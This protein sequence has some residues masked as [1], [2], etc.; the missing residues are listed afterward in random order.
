MST[1]QPPGL[2]PEKPSLSQPVQPSPMPPYG[3][4]SPPP[5]PPSETGWLSWLT[6]VK[7][8]TISNVLVI[9][10]L[11]VVA[12]P[13]YVIYKALGDEK[14]LDRFLST[15]EE[16]TSQITGCVIRHVQERGGPDLWSVSSGFAFQGADRWF[17]SVVL[18]HEPSNDETETYCESLKLIADK[19]LDRGRAGGAA[20]DV[21]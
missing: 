2:P 18:T 4:Q 14:L 3:Q 15:Y 9:A 5:A 6:A 7:G 20:A 1:P 16:K 19:M 11:A 21:Q 8:L 10:A 17:V 12:V 13:V